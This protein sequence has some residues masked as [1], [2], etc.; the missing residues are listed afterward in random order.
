MDEKVIISSDSRNVKG[1]ITRILVYGLVLAVAAAL[2][3]FVMR[4]FG[5]FWALTGVVVYV[6]VLCIA[7]AVWS[8]GTCSITVTAKRVYGMAKFKKRIDIPLDSVTSIG[9]VGLLFKGISISSPSGNISFVFIKNYKDIYD[10]LG[11]II[12][13]RKTS[14]STDSDQA[15][16]IR[17]YKKLLDDG[18]ITQEEFEAKKKELLGM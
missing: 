4:L 12:A 18:I 9:M 8:I 17:K 10:K 16:D 14:E 6:I 1:V 13:N 2:V 3:A 11:N 7:L 5:E 15:D